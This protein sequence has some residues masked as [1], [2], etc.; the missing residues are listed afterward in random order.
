MNDRAVSDKRLTPDVKPGAPSRLMRVI[1][2]V[3]ALRPQPARDVGIDTEVVFGERLRAF[4]EIEGW[5][6]VQAVRDDY[7]G[8][9]SANALEGA[10]AEPTHRL[11]TLRSYIYA[12][13]SIKVPDPVLIVEGALLTVLRVEGDFAVL[14]SGGYVFARHLAPIGSAEPDYVSVAERYI[15]TPYL[16]GGRTS[17]GLDCSGLVQT[18]LRAAG[19]EAPRDSDMLERFYPVSL[20]ITLNFTNLQRGDAIFWKGHVGVMRDSTTLLH[21]NGHHM[22]VASE[23]LADA[24]ARILAKS[25]GPVTSIRRLA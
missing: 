7:V 20:P 1:E 8:F 18:A 19:V 5:A 4:D 13:P 6:Y 11:C 10:G 23:P 9:V 25:F 22:A 2:P 15:G 17:L 14:D 24:A 12:G 16:W 21:A 3:T